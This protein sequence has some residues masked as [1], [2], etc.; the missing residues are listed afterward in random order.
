MQDDVDVIFRNVEKGYT[1]K[2]RIYPNKE[3]R[4]HIDTYLY[5]LEKAANITLYELKM[6]NPCI[7][8]VDS[9]D[10]STVWP[11][12]DKMVIASN[13]L[14]KLREQNPAIRAVPGGALSLKDGLFL[15]DMKK[16]WEK[17]GKLPVD[18]WFEAKQTSGKDKG[19]PLVHFY[20]GKKKKKSFCTQITANKFII[21]EDGR[22]YVTPSKELGTMR[23]RGWND[24]LTFG[25]QNLTFFEYYKGSNKAL[26]CRISKLV[27]GENEAEYYIVIKLQDVNRPFKVKKER[28]SNGFDVN[29]NEDTGVVTSAGGK[30]RNKKFKS[31][32]Q[33]QI[34]AYDMLLANR[35]GY[36]NKNFK[37]NCKKIRIKNKRLKYEDKQP[38]PEPSNRYKKMAMAKRKL[39]LKVARQRDAYQNE[40]SAIE[41]GKSSLIG[42]E[43]L[44]VKGMLRDTNRSY[45]IS[46]A[47]FSSQ[48]EKIRY[49]SAWL[50]IPVIEVGRFFP[51]SHMCPDCGYRFSG[52]EYFGTN[53]RNFTCPD[54]G[55][56]WNRDEAAALNI[57]REAE[58]IYNDPKL[59][60]EYLAKKEEEKKSSKKKAKPKDK[61]LDKNHPEIIIHYDEN[62]REMY[63]NPWIV[64]SENGTVLD[65]AQGYGYDTAQKAI[66]AYKY[67]YLCKSA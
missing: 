55:S 42:I 54:C 35:Q 23:V 18:K 65:D 56:V 30:Y 16:A 10:S 3:A 61:I 59:Y 64:V 29:V 43:S 11:N 20:K 46:D 62:M 15:G 32:L 31:R 49:K 45:S 44:N 26:S 27:I 57:Q 33:S 5:G 7:I 60:A 39:E 47:A 12:F 9:N 4:E 19:K 6:H 63:K 67:K 25:P 1:M 52:E 24:K 66:K 28:V 21:D 41:V 53:V 8:N 14:D 34:S 17:Q 36:K 37:E 51:S 38:L 13:W 22:I 50:D 48:L 2:C 40:I 58:R